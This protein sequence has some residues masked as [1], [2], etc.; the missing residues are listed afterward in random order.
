MSDKKM[1]KKQRE[2]RLMEL[3]ARIEREVEFI[4]IKQYSHN[5]ISLNLRIISKEFGYNIANEAIDEFG[6]T[7]LG[8]S[9]VREPNKVRSVK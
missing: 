9:H 8:W 3:Y 1:T 7:L 6:L 5:I 2:E 4:D